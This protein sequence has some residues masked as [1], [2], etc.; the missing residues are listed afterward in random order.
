M[1]RALN[2]VKNFLRLPLTSRVSLIEVNTPSQRIPHLPSPQP[3]I[4]A[5]ESADDFSNNGIEAIRAEIRC[6][7]LLRVV[8][9][10]GIILTYII[11]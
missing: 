7:P 3:D 2:A 6:F 4:P 1:R 10:E 9:K 5:D 11:V 8:S